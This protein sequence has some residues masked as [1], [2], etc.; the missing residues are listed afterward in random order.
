MQSRSRSIL[1]GAVERQERASSNPHVPRVSMPTASRRLVTGL[2]DAA[3]TGSVASRCR[4]SGARAARGGAVDES[5]G[6]RSIARSR[7]SRQ[8]PARPD[9]PGAAGA[10]FA[11][12]LGEPPRPDAQCRRESCGRRVLRR[13]LPRFGFGLASRNREGERSGREPR[14]LR[15]AAQALTECRSLPPALYPAGHSARQTAPSAGGRTMDAPNTVGTGSHGNEVDWVLT[16]N[17]C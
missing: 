9:R 15:L 10:A 5:A 4:S 1:P 17:W 16:P 13:S 6:A 12:P 7:W 3:S 11:T 14:H 8:Q 2:P